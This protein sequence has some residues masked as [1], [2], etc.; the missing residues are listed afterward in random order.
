[1]GEDG[2][3]PDDILNY[4]PNALRVLRENPEHIIERYMP[5]IL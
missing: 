5:K 2:I 3:T 4:L 1:M